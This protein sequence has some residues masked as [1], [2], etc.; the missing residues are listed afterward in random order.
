MSC[1][2]GELT[3]RPSEVAAG[4]GSSPGVE[5]RRTPAGAAGGNN[6]PGP[7]EDLS[8]AGVEASGWCHKGCQTVGGAYLGVGSTAAAAGRSRCC[9]SLGWTWRVGVGSEKSA[10]PGLT[11]QNISHDGMP[12]MGRTAPRAA[13]GAT[14][15]ARKPSPPAQLRAA[16]AKWA[17]VTAAAFRPG[18]ELPC[19]T[20]RTNA[21][22]VA[23]PPVV[24]VHDRQHPSTCQLLT[25]EHSAN[26]QRASHLLAATVCVPGLGG[27]RPY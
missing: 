12:R 17:A 25:Q 4:A 18:H 9:S 14:S 6:R 2:D 24:S 22:V 5:V 15:S 11:P 3:H 23:V 16:R 20:A 10:R 27:T 7:G 21:A 19:Y 13:R 26:G 8:W 1:L